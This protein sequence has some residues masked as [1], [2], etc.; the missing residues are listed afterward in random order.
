MKL[1]L[2]T[3]YPIEKIELKLESCKELYH[4]YLYFIEKYIRRNYP[5]IDLF[6]KS[7][8]A[9][10]LIRSSVY[11][12]FILEDTYDHC[13]LVDNRGIAR[14]LPLFHDY[15]REHVTGLV[16]TMS[17]NTGVK[18]AEDVL[19]FC[20]PH[21]KKRM[22]MKRYIG[23]ACDQEMLK[24][25]QEKNTIQILIDH[26]YYGPEKSSIHKKDLTLSI[27]RQVWEQ[28][29]NIKTKKK[30]VVKR[31]CLGGVETLTDDN[32]QTIGEY[33]QNKGLNYF[34]AVKLY[35]S[36]DIFFVTHPE[37]MG[38]VVLECA[39]AGALVVAPGGYIKNELLKPLYN[40][41]LP[42]KE[43]NVEIN[44]MYILSRIDHKLSRERALRFNW[45]KS[46][47]RI[48]DTFK[49]VKKYHRIINNKD[50][51]LFTR[52]KGI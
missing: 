5:N 27:S 14:R 2:L 47:D 43:E 35:N 48:V 13:L 39:M 24:P 38:L 52:P 17:D 29:K 31:F 16:T 20:I 26:N 28:V 18:G 8:P 23:W 7:M 46:V 4:I 6:I 1:L 19:F 41:S 51:Y 50:T 25:E 15:L 36:T 12:N 9:G 49:N 45:S 32:Y 40:V 3:T 37:S 10:Y 42:N 11:E 34:E 22:E 30:I 33:Q 44:M 21:P